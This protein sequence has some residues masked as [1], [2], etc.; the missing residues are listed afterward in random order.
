MQASVHNLESERVSYS[1]VV[2]VI[3]AVCDSEWSMIFTVLIHG[4]HCGH[5]ILLHGVQLEMSHT[6]DIIDNYAVY[7]HNVNCELTLFVN[8]I[9]HA[10]LCFYII[11][12]LF[13]LCM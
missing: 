4:L 12:F 6:V 5:S 11:I 3:A 8:I 13:R 1:P 2:P 9:N 7:A 10:Y